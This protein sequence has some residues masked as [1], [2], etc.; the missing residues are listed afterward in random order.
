MS[1]L[2]SGRVLASGLPLAGDSV[3]ST[4]DFHVFITIAEGADTV[5]GTVH[6]VP[7][8]ANPTMHG[9]IVEG[10]DV[11]AGTVHFIDPGMFALTG[12]V[13]EGADTVSGVIDVLGD[14]VRTITFVLTDEAGDPHINAAGI[15]WVFFD[16]RT[17]TALLAEL[18]TAGFR[19]DG[20]VLNSDASGFVQLGLQITNLVPGET[21]LLLVSNSN[22]SVSAA[23]RSF[24]GPVAVQ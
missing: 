17:L 7:L 19:C 15:P 21:G 1:A 3:T 23:T 24:L 14:A 18:R 20:G 13:V 2:G 4:A 8:G 5:A 22:G 10:A 6:N 11:V 9:S 12:T 16:Q